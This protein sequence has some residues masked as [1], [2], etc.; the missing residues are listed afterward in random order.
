M[1]VPQHSRADRGQVRARIIHANVP[2]SVHNRPRIQLTQ[3]GTDRREVGNVHLLACQD[4]VWDAPEIAQAGK[5]LCPGFLW[6]Q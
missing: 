1:A 6:L 2:S 4:V 3:S 5:S